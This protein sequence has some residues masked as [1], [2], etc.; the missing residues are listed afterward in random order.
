MQ[1][2]GI[3]HALID[4]AVA[5]VLVVV[6]AFLVVTAVA[7]VIV[8]RVRRRWRAL[9]AAT[10]LAS[11]RGWAAQQARRRMWRAVRAADH[12]VAVARR[13]EVSVGDLPTLARQ[14]E[15]AARSTDALVLATA[16]GPRGG[17]PAILEVRRVEEAALQIHDAA[18]VS[19]QTAASADV[20]PLL[21]T[22][23]LEAAA[24]AAGSRA[25]SVL[26]RPAT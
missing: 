13:A 10:T 24:L 5:V 2:T 17:R 18:V 23:R 11:P 26:H 21:S 12:A 6:V 4:A 7:T 8:R 14:L 3:E 9:A 16:R 25:A 1:L 20:D 22:V 15:A 19:L